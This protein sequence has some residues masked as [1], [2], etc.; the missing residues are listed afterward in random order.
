M[1]GQRKR[2]EEAQQYSQSFLSNHKWGYLLQILMIGTL[3]TDAG[4][5]K[6]GHRVEMVVCI[7]SLFPTMKTKNG[8][9]VT[10]LDNHLSES[11][12]SF[13]MAEKYGSSTQSRIFPSSSESEY[14]DPIDNNG[15]VPCSV[16]FQNSDKQVNEVLNW[17]GR[18]SNKNIKF[19]LVMRNHKRPLEAL[20]PEVLSL[21][22][23][24]KSNRAGLN[25]PILFK[26]LR[27]VKIR[28][29]KSGDTNSVSFLPKGSVVIINRSS[30]CSGR[31]VV[32]QQN[33][34][35]TKIGI[36]SWRT[37][38]TGKVQSN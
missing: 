22:F 11:P 18:H 37:A 19:N 17:I 5:T 24:G 32:Q 12:M 16:K 29:G 2:C 23:R 4:I 38:V 1:F 27:K 13:T 14:P 35:Y 31:V 7:R 30:G 6:Y 20:P 36:Y 21:R 9:E 28:S 26:A 15:G 10:K 34:E 3:K 33:G 8:Q 25:N